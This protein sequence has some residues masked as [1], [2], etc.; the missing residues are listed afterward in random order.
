MDLRTH[1][2]YALERG[3]WITERI[4]G[5]FRNE[6]DW[7]YRAHDAANF[8]LWIAGHLG[9]ADN[10]FQGRFR[11]ERKSKPDGWD[12]LF[13]FGS[14]LRDDRSVYP[15]PDEVLAYFRERR[16]SLLELVDALSDDELNAPA[17]PRDALDPIAGAPCLGEILLFAAR[18]ESMHTGQLTVAHRGLGYPPLFAP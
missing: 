12:E 18:H 8:P 7:F 14:H 3:R 5:D 13:W 2:R 4:L 1:A 15:T 17:P 11:P 9:L 10:A 6:S 16:E